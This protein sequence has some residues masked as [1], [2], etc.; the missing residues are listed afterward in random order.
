MP[1]TEDDITPEEKSEFQKL[2]AAGDQQALMDFINKLNCKY[3]GKPANF[4]DGVHRTCAVGGPSGGQRIDPRMMVGSKSMG[5]FRRYGG[6]K[7]RKSR[8]SR[9]SHKSRKS[10]KSRKHKKTHK[11]RARK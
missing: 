9:K 2:A 8:K 11:K 5:T 1:F 4:G 6:K 3:D 7:A 10:R